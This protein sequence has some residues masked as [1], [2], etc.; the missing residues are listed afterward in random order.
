MSRC[1]LQIP[2][3]L[4]SCLIVAFLI[5][6]AILYPKTP[7]IR[8]NDVSLSNLTWRSDELTG[9]ISANLTLTVSVTMENHN[10]FGAH[11]AA[12]P[13][14]VVLFR[15]EVPQPV[16]TMHLPSGYIGPHSTLDLLLSSD[17][18]ETELSGTAELLRLAQHMQV[19]AQSEARGTVR[20]IGIEVPW[21]VR[22]RCEAEC[23]LNLWSMEVAIL[24][25]QCESH[26]D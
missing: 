10:R 23:T 19:A 13:I 14:D 1:R 21:K 5:A 16:T 12:S 15:D 9:R 20:L 11:F 6:L 3:V 18:R 4:V 22:T 17:I 8:T 2:V 7:T 24:R 26:A 25:Q